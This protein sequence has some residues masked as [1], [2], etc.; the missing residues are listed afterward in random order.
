MSL[1]KWVR[2][3]RTPPL[4]N[5]VSSALSILLSDVGVPMSGSPGVA[6]VKGARHPVY[7]LSIPAASAALASGVLSGMLH[8]PFSA[9]YSGWL[10]DEREARALIDAAHRVVKMR[11]A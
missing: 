7:H 6:S 11:K 9:D 4:Q 3:R 5:E 10:I 2:L 8:R 1:R